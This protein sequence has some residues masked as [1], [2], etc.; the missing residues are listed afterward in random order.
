[1]T[2][3]RVLDA[4]ISEAPK[5]SPPT[6]VAA[7][8]ESSAS[9]LSGSAYLKLSECSQRPSVFITYR[10]IPDVEFS[11][12]LERNPPRAERASNLSAEA[13]SESIKTTTS[14]EGTCTSC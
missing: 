9:A 7:A 6:C 14:R 10:W 13:S 4:E 1:M 12:T 11:E 5:E 3:Y 8:S 2:R